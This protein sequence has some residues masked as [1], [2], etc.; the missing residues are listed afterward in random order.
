MLLLNPDDEEH[1]LMLSR[2]YL[3][4][5]V[6]LDEVRRIILLS[7]TYS[8]LIKGNLFEIESEKEAIR[9]MP[10]LY[11]LVRMARTNSRAVSNRLLFA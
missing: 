1:R 7:R 8:I 2:I 3:H 6:N 9:G 4:H 11:A 5:G 10:G